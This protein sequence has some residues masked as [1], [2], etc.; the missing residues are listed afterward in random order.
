VYGIDAAFS[1]FDN[2]NFNG[3][4][5]K[6]KT[7]G[8]T[9]GE[10]ASY[11]AAFS[12]NGDKYRVQIDHLLV[13]DTFNPEIGFLRR[14]DIRRTFTQAQYRPRPRSISAVRQFTFGANL[15]YVERS[16]TGQLETGV[17]QA[18][19]ETEF[20]NSDRFVV[21]VQESHERLRQNFQLT[22]AVA[23]AVGAYDFRD[24]LVGYSMGEQRPVSGTWSVQSG[25]YFDGHITAVTYQRGRIALTRQLSVQ[26]GLS[27]NHIELPVAR[28][29]LKLITSRV[30]Y[31]V[32]P[33]MFVSGLTQYNSSTSSLGTNLR[34]R[35]EYQPGSELFVVYNDLQDTSRSGDVRLLNRSFVVKLTRQFRL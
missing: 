29:T 16:S 7:P 27:I 32:T 3:Y 33:R 26:P 10:D 24:I 31:T 20:H 23:V 6:A 22:P 28:I 17:A 35:W 11:Q 1:F 30:T 9:K 4:Y 21:D 34:F 14:N 12:Y 25:Q 5:A 15:D 2:V 18:R 13:G 8:L 19:F